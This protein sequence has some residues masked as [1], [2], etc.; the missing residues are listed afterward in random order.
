MLDKQLSS[1]KLSFDQKAHL[2]IEDLIDDDVLPLSEELVDL[3][4][5]EEK[6]K[7]TAD[8]CERIEGRQDDALRIE[9][10][11]QLQIKKLR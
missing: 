7:Q 11:Q 4:A 5:V 2:S 8:S 10:R 9:V 1:K 3:V 6:R